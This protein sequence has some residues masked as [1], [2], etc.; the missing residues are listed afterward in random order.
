MSTLIKVYAIINDLVMLFY[1]N[2]I[3]SLIKLVDI[4][5]KW[6]RKKRKEKHMGVLITCICYA[7]HVASF[8]LYTFKTLYTE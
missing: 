8:I 5:K 1:V 2:T 7:N 4:C 3:E 6:R